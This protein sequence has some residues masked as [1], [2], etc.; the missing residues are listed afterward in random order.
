VVWWLLPHTAQ[1]YF[2]YSA[3]KTMFT[4]CTICINITKSAY[5][6]IVFVDS[7]W[8]PLQTLID[9]LNSIIQLVFVIEALCFLCC[10]NW[11]FKI[12]D[13]NFRLSGWS[14]MISYLNYISSCG[15][16]QVRGQVTYVMIQSHDAITVGLTCFTLQTQ[17]GAVQSLALLL[18]I[19]MY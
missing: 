12:I 18:L 13:I 17:N 6:H 7:V 8:L 1:R 11:M 4:V 10:K 2:I 16:C 3:S 19:W 14:S 5:P 15:L 9:S